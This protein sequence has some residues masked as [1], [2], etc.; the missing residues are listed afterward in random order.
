MLAALNG[1][2][3]NT[4]AANA[5]ELVS[6]Q[7]QG[8]PSRVDLRPQFEEMKLTQRR[9][10][11]RGTCSVFVTVEAV[12]FAVA[13]AI[14]STQRLSVEFANWAANASTRRSDDGDFFHNIIR[15]IEKYGICQEAAMPYERS[16]SPACMPSPAATNQANLFREDISLS[17]HWIKRWSRDP[18][19][20]DA[21]LDKIKSVLANGYPV[22]AGSYHSILFVGYENDSALPGGGRF[23]VADS[24]MAEREISYEAARKRMSDLFWVSAQSKSKA[25][26]QTL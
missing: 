5:P 15:G 13:R 12:E 16:F 21:D 7:S 6:Q 8:L 1:A 3:E 11:E 22:S 10:G 18:G 9:Q 19:L 14:G 23:F 2:L 17:F 4:H 26:A 20:N 24:N 25:A